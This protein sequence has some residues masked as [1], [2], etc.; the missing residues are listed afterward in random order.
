[1]ASAH[2]NGSTGPSRFADA[3]ANERP[4]GLPSSGADASNT[5]SSMSGSTAGGDAWS[6]Y[7][8]STGSGF[9]GEGLAGA[10][11]FGDPGDGGSGQPPAAPTRAVKPTRQIS[12]GAQE[13]LTVTALAD[14]EGVFMFQHRNYE[15]A[16][17]RKNIRVVRR[18]S[19]FNWL[20]DCLYKKYPFRQLPL[21]PPKR[22]SSKHASMDLFAGMSSANSIS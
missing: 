13:V 16:S 9:G 10:E 18:Y 17:S 3:P 19:D 11:G 20:L 15:I 22:V 7:N 4:S 5:A 12:H 8:G 21:L 6:G 2:Q 14:K 1:M